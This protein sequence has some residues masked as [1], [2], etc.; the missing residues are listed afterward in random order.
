MGVGAGWMLRVA[1]TACLGTA[2]VV[3]GCGGSAGRTQVAPISVSLI[4][5]TVTVKND[6]KPVSVGISIQSTSE[7]A[8]VML[9]GLPGG[10]G[11]TYAASDTNPSGT[12]TFTANATAK[13]GTAMPVI[14]VN[15]AGQT[16][17]VRFTL[18]VSASPG[19]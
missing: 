4:N 3:A 16:A 18:N 10:V 2:V 6:G 13:A 1:I 14:A 19:L 15:S 8:L 7:T 17:M 11:F 9:N 5:S 12:L